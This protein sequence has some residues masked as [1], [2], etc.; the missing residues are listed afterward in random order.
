MTGRS[1]LPTVSS[2]LPLTGCEIAIVSRIYLPEPAAASFRLGALARALRDAGATTRVLTSTP[3]PQYA[4]SVSRH[5]GID[6]RRAPVLRDPAGYVRGYAHYMSFD[7]PAFFRL[8]FA[9]PADV[10]VVEP[11]P[12]TGFFVRIAC[13]LRR[14]PYVYYAAD[15]WADAVATTNAPRPVVSVVRGLERWAMR[16]AAAIISTSTGVTTR[17]AELDSRLTVTT[18]GNGVD[19]ELF[20]AEGPARD[21]GAPYLLYAGTASEVHGAGIFLEAFRLVC[22]TNPVARLVFVGQGAEREEFER[23]AQTLPPGSVVFEPRLPPAEVAE[24][25][26][27]AVATLASVKPGGY[28]FAFPTKMYASVSCGTRVIYAGVG[29]GSAFAAIDGLGWSVG[30][31]ATVIADAMRAALDAPVDGEQ[32]R[33][34][35]RWAAENVS[36]SAVA[37]R[38][39]AVIASIAHR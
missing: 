28:E 20:S 8:V 1:I 29:P 33:R 12:T 11:P 15:I 4:E 25:I 30:Y 38:A 3:P 10:V 32:R 34:V 31:E 19:T 22:E 24:W 7:I 17:L 18:V 5:Q 39:V 9:R 14:T 6:V 37:E 26:R 36:L 2:T 35:S 23:I 16:G 27:G 13:L 21:V